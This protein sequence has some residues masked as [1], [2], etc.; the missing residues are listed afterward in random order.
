M[1]SLFFHFAYKEIYFFIYNNSAYFICF[2][3]YMKVS[4]LCKYAAKL[5]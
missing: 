2:V 5:Y 3:V 1:K 4:V